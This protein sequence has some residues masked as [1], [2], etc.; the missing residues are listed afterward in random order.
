LKALI[1][2]FTLLLMTLNSVSSASM[3]VRMSGPETVEK[4]AQTL[5]PC[6][7]P[8]MMEMPADDMVEAA[9][10]AS[11]SYKLCDMD[12][13]QCGHF[14]TAK[15]PDEIHPYAANFIGFSMPLAMAIP[16]VLTPFLP[17]NHRPPRIMPA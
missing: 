9:K 7:Q 3:W 12:D 13:C 6:H 16:S 11:P 17:L 5:P 14:N 2:L 8:H 1:I 4:V 10:S 15:V